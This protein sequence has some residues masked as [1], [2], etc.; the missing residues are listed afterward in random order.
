M[1]KADQGTLAADDMPVPAEVIETPLIEDKVEP[2]TYAGTFKGADA[3]EKGYGELQGRFD[4]QGNDLGTARTEI[5]NLQS[6]LAEAQKPAEQIAP[7]N[8][9]EADQAKL[10]KAYED[11]D[12]TFPEY[13]KQSNAVTA[14]AV[15]VQ[16]Q[17]QVNE[18]LGKAND[19]FNQTLSD[20]DDQVQV[21]KFHE[22]YPDFAGLQQS[23]A[24][25]GIRQNNPMFDDVTAYFAL[26]AQNAKD[27][28]KAEQARIEA[29]SAQ[30]GKVVADPGTAMQ[31]PTKTP[32][33]PQEVKASML[34][35]LNN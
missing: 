25:N 22:T 27:A 2:T 32:T 10:A 13:S 15:N 1:P 33:T 29:G 9:Y 23:G 16:A 7:A 6:Q 5:Q 20:R 14:Q 3:L 31:Q 18:I 35:A 12:I 17:A 19:Q 4:T 8:D 28:G 26:T 11:G 21:D 30:A 24:L 34:A